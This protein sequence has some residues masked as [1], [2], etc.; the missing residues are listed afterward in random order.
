MHF[1]LFSTD[2][3]DS[4]GADIGFEVRTQRGFVMIS[5][6]MSKIE[7]TAWHDLVGRYDGRSLSLFCDGRLMVSKPCEGKLVHNEE[8][9]LIGAETDGGKVVRNMRGELEE[10]GLWGR[11]LS[12]EEI[13]LL[14][15]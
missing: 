9:L 14:S 11:G 8:P 5:F 6:P 2:L 15:L 12:D 7:P 13:G 1:N 4:K 10:A 3:P